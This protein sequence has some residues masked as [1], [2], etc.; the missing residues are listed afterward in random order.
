HQ[1]RCRLRR[2]LSEELPQVSEGAASRAIRATAYRH[3]DQIQQIGAGD[4]ADVQRVE[5]HLAEGYGVRQ[6]A[7]VNGSRGLLASDAA[8][9]WILEGPASPGAV[10]QPM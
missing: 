5:D 3:L 7:A 6:H 1:F 10:Q 8:H 2:I 4:L 9:L